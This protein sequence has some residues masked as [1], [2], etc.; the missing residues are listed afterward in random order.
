MAEQN[1]SQKN[2]GVIQTIDRTL[3]KG[4]DNIDGVLRSL[5]NKGGTRANTTKQS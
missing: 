5:I 4:V 3:K 2:D 1:N